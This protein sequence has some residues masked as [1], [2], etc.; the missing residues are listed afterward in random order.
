MKKIICVILSIILLTTPFVTEAAMEQNQII[1]NDVLTVTKLME[2]LLEKTYQKRV[3]D[4]KKDIAMNNYDYELTMESCNIQGNPFSEMDYVSLVAAY[5]TVKENAKKTVSINDINF[6]TYS[7]S[8]NSIE[9]K[10]PIAIEEYSKNSNGTYSVS[11]KRYITDDME[12]DIYQKI[13]DTEYKKNGTKQ[14]NLQKKLIKYGEIQ[15]KVLDPENLLKKYQIDNES[16]RRKYAERKAKINACISGRG[17]A[18]SIFVNLSMKNTLSEDI[19]N[20]I[21]E[22]KESDISQNKKILLNTA[23]SLIGNVPYEWGGK[24]TKPGYDDTW[25][26]FKD[27][28]KQKGLDCSGYIEWV[29]KTAGYSQEIWDKMH[30]TSSVL[31]NFDTITKDELEVGDLGLLNNGENVNHVGIDLGNILWIHCSSGAST[32]VINNFNFRVFKKVNQIDTESIIPTD[33]VINTVNSGEYTDED[34]YLLAQT[35]SHEAKGEGLNGWIGV[36]EVILN[37]IQSPDFGD[38]LNDVIYQEGQFENAN[39]IT[40]EEPDQKI[41]EI[42]RMMLNGSLRI[43]NNPDVLYFRN[44]KG[45]YVSDWGPFKMFTPINHHA[46]Y[47]GNSSN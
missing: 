14:I 25:W 23:M 17:L 7:I 27:N 10:E 22:L 19:I 38:T 45:D 42:S 6:L 21:S 15:F 40:L 39:E 26:T 29:F 18:Q 1:A 4:I 30:S 9:E 37:R 8:E 46:F 16:V 34:V 35:I 41:L 20:Y 3:E 11:G 31:K 43:F 5:T 32:V 47:L 36:G 28:G 24:S 2:I 12:I 44:P 33:V 13:N